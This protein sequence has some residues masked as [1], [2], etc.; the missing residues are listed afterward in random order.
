MAPTL[1]LYNTLTR[2]KEEFR[3]INPASVRMYVCGPTVYDYAHIG[4]ARPVIV[5]DLLFRL[6]RHLYGPEH[7]TYV[8]N[9]TDVD[10]KINARAAE[11]GVP[12]RDITE[13]TLAQFHA[14]IAA[15]GV[16]EPTVEPRATEHIAEMRTL[17]ERLVANRHAY[18]AEEHV[19]FDVPSMPDYG[20]L[21]K[22]PLDE[23]EAGARVDVAPYK[24][25]A[26]DF[27][28]WKPSKP[29]EPSW[30]SPAGIATP[31]RP[32][33]HIECSA[34]SW[35]HLGEAFDIHG[36]GIDLVFPHH[37]NEA[38]QTRCS[39]GTPAMANVWMHNGFLKVEGEKM[40]KSL[41]NLF[42]INELLTTDVFGGR[43]WS[44]EVLRL[45]MLT[46]HYRQP[47]DWTVARLRE[48]L[49]ALNKFAYWVWEADESGLALDY[50]ARAAHPEVVNALLDDL[51]TPE[52]I[53]SLHRQIGDLS[54]REKQRDPNHNRRI[55][56]F[57]NSLTLLGLKP[58]RRQT[59][60]DVLGDRL[61]LVND[62]VA[63]RLNARAKK[64]WAES[65]RI[66]DELA[67]MGITL[68]DN[69]DGTTTWEVTR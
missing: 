46:A 56:E 20:R 53:A 45:A 64:N 32:G 19:L 65:D 68:K 57:R 51:N 66:R 48:A 52:A 42:T 31:G 39:F 8:R 33:W 62:L 26:P 44:G 60:E 27:V 28:L 25:S 6:L 47:I 69:K 29:G 43:S 49:R 58:G 30:P 41:G 2:T 10:D 34:M 55:S 7:V 11:R 67:G 24:R 9:V 63:A 50:D 13:G 23:M 40:S 17:I 1:R 18:V 36:G 4:N 38:A 3:P 54:N 14:D 35:K 61:P 15:L 22:R 59:T 12:I 5:F 21:S 37:E 16:L